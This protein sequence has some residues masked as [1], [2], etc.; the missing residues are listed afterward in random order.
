MRIVFPEIENPIIKE[1]LGLTPEVEAV[2]ADDID[3]ACRILANGDAEAMIAGIDYTSRDVILG[4]RDI[5]GATGKTFS[6]CFV[7]ER[8]KEKIIIA[9]GATCKNP[10]EE[11]LFDIVCQTFETAK[12][13]FPEPKIA[14]LSFSTLG[15]G[16][17][18]DSMTKIQNVITK[19]RAE[20]PEIVIDGEMQLDAA[21]NLRVAEKKAPGSKV[22]GKANVLIC[23]DLNSGNILYKAL[24]QFGGFVAAGPILQ[25][26]K[27]PI[28]DL[29]RGS[30]VED[31]V[32]VIKTI[33]RI[34]NG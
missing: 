11:Q 31:V 13:I 4:A 27:K 6:S 1:A 5:V 34:V 15:S 22:A 28:S 12:H 3:E 21:V 24:E 16:G 17:H 30:T 19:V 8:E 25:G 20:R 10:T 26:F 7:L 23:P 14:M 29:S 32:L 18:D 9:D 33:E 2:P